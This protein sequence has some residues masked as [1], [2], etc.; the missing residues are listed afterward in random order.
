MLNHQ[1]V[2]LKRRR[3]SNPVVQYV[4]SLAAVIAAYM[5]YSV[6]A[7]PL[8]EGPPNQFQATRVTSKI[9]A[10]PR[11]RDKSWLKP[12]VPG[13]GW[14]LDSCKTV[15]V[16][17][18]TI[19]FCD[20]Q[21]LD[22]GY[23]DV[24][25][26]TLILNAKPPR[27]DGTPAFNDGSGRMPITIRCL[28]QARLKF[29]RPLEE[30]VSY[31]GLKLEGARL[32]GDVTIYRPPSAVGKPDGVSVT[33]SNIQIDPNQIF[34]LEQVQFAF[35]KNKGVGRNLRIE[36]DRTTQGSRNPIGSSG[37]AG[38]AGIN[39]IELASLSRL[40]LE[41]G[42][43]KPAV[44]QGSNNPN[45]AGKGSADLFSN[46][47]APLEVSCAGPFAFN[48]RTSTA[49]LTDQVY[50]EQQDQ[51]RDRLD[52][53]QLVLKFTDSTQADSLA[54]QTGLTLETFYGK[55]TPARVVAHSRN[56]TISGNQLSYDV[57]KGQ[58][59]ATSNH[60]VTVETPEFQLLSR[61]LN[62]SVPDDGS[63]GPVEA[64]GPGRLLRLGG[65]DRKPL[66]VKWQ[67]R[68]TV[69]PNGRQQQVTID[70][71]SHVHLGH[72]I[73]LAAEE[74]KLWLE[75]TLDE[76]QPQSLA[77]QDQRKSE[78]WDPSRVV[79]S[80]DVRIR[81]P[82]LD[83]TAE[84]LT[85]AWQGAN[86]ITPLPDNGTLD[87]NVNATVPTKRHTVARVA[88]EGWSTVQPTQAGWSTVPPVA[89][90]ARQHIAQPINVQTNPFA[91]RAEGSDAKVAPQINR[92]IAKPDD[93]N[94][95]IEFHGREVVV[96]LK[97]MGSDTEIADLKI[98]G[99][100]RVTQ[101]TKTQQGPTIHTI[102]GAGLRLTPQANKQQ[103]VQILGTDSQ[104]AQFRSD[105]LNL[106]GKKIF[107]DQLANRIWVEGQGQL[108]LNPNQKPDG[109]ASAQRNRD[110]GPAN[111][112]FAPDQ[113]K[114]ID[115]L[116]VKWGAGMVF[117][118]RKIYFEE[119]VAMTTKS[120]PDRDGTT[121]QARS[122]SQG[123]S[124]GLTQEVRIASE[125]RESS[126]VSID[127]VVLVDKITA[128]KR[129]FQLASGNK[130]NTPFQL[131]GTESATNR[132]TT[133]IVIEHTTFDVG[134]KIL[135][136]Q[137]VIAPQATY[138]ATTGM[139]RANGPGAIQLHRR[140]KSKS[141]DPSGRKPSSTPSDPNAI[142]L[143]HVKFDDRLIADSNKKQIQIHGQVRSLT[144]PVRSFDT[145]FD[146]DQETSTWP[147]DAVKLV[148]QQVQLA[149]WN[150]QSSDKPSNEMVATGNAHIISSKFEAT[151]DR[152]SYSQANDMLVV[153]G[154]TRS[155]ANLWFRRNPAARPDHLVAGKILYRLSD[156]WTEV[157]NVR[158]V[159][160]KSK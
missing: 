66:L 106:D 18:G 29:D 158:N 1:Q 97:R 132:L 71:Q 111:N 89:R 119:D 60:Q 61:E 39:R 55:G 128:D 120:A 36:L 129:V 92:S 9:D 37:F 91:E 27:A 35:G 96:Q 16:E 70:G 117:D 121:T 34:T 57:A 45:D 40:R 67:K 15:T 143:T 69:T 101:T 41:P 5:L 56:T 75:Q 77:T 113:L 7:V 8:L 42:D 115:K 51:N 10:Q 156:Q 72:D 147:V 12:F 136:R 155:D 90:I 93:A 94:R 126:G 135:E 38:V 20:Y 73:S 24:Y 151:A 6:V 127:E 44:A 3:Q 87:S 139:I 145:V 62:Y 78:R 58:F 110:S 153:E 108:W 28:K 144:S 80:G 118:G 102:A 26:F 122:F 152:V 33:T 79:A 68:M 25:P 23:A 107:V 125:G 32:I 14:E 105:E 86:G 95:K 19:L 81:T 109:L 140:G 142:T 21:P 99:N 123:L 137:T 103:R 74:I 49:T 13:D 149:Q 157:Q 31:G 2:T 4:L 50:V 11:Q 116:E 53:E 154:T 85:A 112:Q 134:E 104:P 133:P 82:Q 64:N 131:A 48:F 52:C 159:K 46:S 43:K 30:G 76:H 17:G 148:C 114:A 84:R 22:D 83:G 141:L 138:A 63:M 146:P 59:Q 160:I 100:V 88:Q 124:I 54:S 47:S 98:D 150:P 130:T 65:T